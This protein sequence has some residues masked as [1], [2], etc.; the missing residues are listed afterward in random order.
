LSSLGVSPAA[1][2][3][4]EALLSASP[5]PDPPEALVA[6]LADL[7]LIER[8]GTGY[9]AVPPEVGLG[10]LLLARER[11]LMQVRGR[12][13]RLAV[14]HHSAPSWTELGEPVEIIEDKA[15]ALRRHAELLDAAGREI[16]A[17]D[18]PPFV[19]DPQQANDGELGA[20]RRGVPVRVLYDRQSLDL[21]VRL[22]DLEVGIRAG[23]QARVGDT[24]G[25]LTLFDR[26]LAMVVSATAAYVMLVRDPT[27]VRALVA[28]FE[29]YWEAGTPLHVNGSL[30][31]D[32]VEGPN[33]TERALL[34]LLASG[35]TDAE[36][37][38]RLGW[39]DRAVRRYVAG[40]FA[41]LDATTRFQAGHQAY[42]RGW[43]RP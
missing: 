12:L 20:L 17:V 16:C 2:R 39:S 40:L 37:G 5:V 26:S 41:R 10:G 21:P 34:S 24:P 6:E 15:G 32:L 23:E 7:G 3:V 43:L 36:I 25:K 1:Q 19:G 38:A 42:T 28:L 14:R 13:A 8:T 29:T 31:D 18:A 27:L 11:E 22:A 9:S 33:D 30:V 35:H 4:Y